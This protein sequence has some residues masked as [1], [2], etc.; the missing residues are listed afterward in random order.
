MHASFD[1]VRAA[2]Q[3]EIIHY[4]DTC[5]QI[6]SARCRG[7]DNRRRFSRLGAQRCVQRS[8]CNERLLIE[9]FASSSNAA[10]QHDQKNAFSK[11]QCLLSA[12]PDLE[13]LLRDARSEK[14]TR[15]MLKAAAER[16]LR[17]EKVVILDALNNIKGYRW[18][19]C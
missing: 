12:Y 7:A 15:A 5:R 9:D 6:A 14:I 8:D 11:A 1:I 2:M 4:K 17:G 18:R 16:S 3:R 19:P 13:H 10:Y